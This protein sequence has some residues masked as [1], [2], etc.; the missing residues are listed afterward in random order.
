MYMCWV[1]ACFQI[2]VFMFEFTLNAT[3]YTDERGKTLVKK[4]KQKVLS[5]ELFTFKMSFY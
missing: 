2:N 1:F 5:L 4:T 3:R